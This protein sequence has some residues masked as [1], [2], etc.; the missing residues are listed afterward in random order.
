M[1]NKVGLILITLFFSI[2]VYATCGAD[3]CTADQTDPIKRIYLTNLSDGQIYIEAPSG[4]ENLDCT[5]AEGKF[6]VLTAS[7]PL[8]KETYSTILAA[9]MANKKLLIRIRNGSTKC[10]VAYVQLYL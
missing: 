10:E 8:F 4:K 1:Y 3:S 2:N 7:H 9:V 5:L 6:M